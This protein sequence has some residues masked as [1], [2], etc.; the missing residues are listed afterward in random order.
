[1][2]HAEQASKQATIQAVG[3]VFFCVFSLFSG[4]G[5][6][7]MCMITGQEKEKWTERQQPKRQAGR[8]ARL[9]AAAAGQTT[10]T[11]W[12]DSSGS[13]RKWHRGLLHRRL[14][15]LR[16][17]PREAGLGVQLDR[18][19]AEPAVVSSYYLGHPDHPVCCCSSLSARC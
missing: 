19:M 18:T 17:A 9:L 6:S 3:V 14:G 10:R 13:R 7:I 12:P 4:S 8:A 5:L 11:T 16:R 15:R 2:C 1:M